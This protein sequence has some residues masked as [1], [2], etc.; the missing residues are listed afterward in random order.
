MSLTPV[1]PSLERKTTIASMKHYMYMTEPKSLPRNH[2]RK[3]SIYSLEMFSE[4]LLQIFRACQACIIIDKTSCLNFKFN[5]L[6]TFYNNT[7]LLSQ[8]ILKGHC[9]IFKTHTVSALHSK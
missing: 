2:I 6:Q 9:V 7:E 5:D 1:L 3:Y 8:D 4:L